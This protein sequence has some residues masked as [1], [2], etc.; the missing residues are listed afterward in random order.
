M[1][2]SVKAR[3]FIDTWRHLYDIVVIVLL[4][5]LICYNLLSKV[6]ILLSMLLKFQ[7]F[8]SVLQKHTKQ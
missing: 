7:I 6:L 1:H 3:A 4:S 8:E 2:N 5:W